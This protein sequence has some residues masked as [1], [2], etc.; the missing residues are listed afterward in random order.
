M[1]PRSARMDRVGTR[2]PASG[3]GPSS[4]TFIPVLV[5][6]AVQRVFQH[7][8]R[9]AGVLADHHPVAV[10]AIAAGN[11]APPQRPAAAPF[12]PSSDRYWPSPD[13]V[14][15]EKL[16]RHRPVLSVTAR[17]SANP[18]TVA[19][20]SSCPVHLPPAEPASVTPSVPGILS[21]G[22]A[23][24]ATSPMKRARYAQQDPAA[25]AVKQAD[26]VQDH[27][28]M[29]Q[30]LAK[31]DARIDQNARARNAAP[32]RAMRVASAS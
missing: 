3:T 19:A 1:I 22:T 5:R 27:Q 32:R 23:W 28:I 13:P 6:P 14:R 18:C 2:P 21:R 16:P 30:R 25:E 15:P 9:Q 8:A 7:I 12:P 31:T 24:A 11:T 26:P 4:S 10:A 29:V 20:T 17:H